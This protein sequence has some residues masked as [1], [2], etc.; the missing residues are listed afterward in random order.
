M[1]VDM[2]VSTYKEWYTSQAQGLHEG[3]YIT[4]TTNTY[5]ITNINH[6]CS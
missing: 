3:V 2:Y 6:L 5:A 4:Q 1:Y